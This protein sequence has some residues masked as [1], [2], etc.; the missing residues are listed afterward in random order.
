MSPTT[1]VEPSLDA[2]TMVASRA[3]RASWATSLRVMAV[4]APASMPSYR[5]MLLA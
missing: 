3:F 4:L 5:S 2:S 1:M